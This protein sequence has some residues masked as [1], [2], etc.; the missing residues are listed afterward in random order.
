MNEGRQEVWKLT[1]QSQKL[2]QSL[3]AVAKA[4]SCWFAEAQKCVTLRFSRSRSMRGANINPSAKPSRPDHVLPHHHHSRI[5]D[6]GNAGRT[7]LRI[8]GTTLR[9]RGTTL[10][11]R[12]TT[13]YV[14]GTTLRVRGTTLRARGTTLRARA[15]APRG[16]TTPADGVSD[17]GSDER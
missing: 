15:T 8:R 3:I 13:L 1:H 6:P 10:R 4:K 16:P 7:F 2:T 17:G 14:R 9:I 5:H 11:V 12:G